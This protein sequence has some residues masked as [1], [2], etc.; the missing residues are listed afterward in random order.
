[1][2]NSYL[3]CLILLLLTSYRQLGDPPRQEAEYLRLYHY[4]EGLYNNPNDSKLNDSLA[5][6]SYLKVI[7]L[8][9]N[10]HQNDSVLWDCYFKAGIYEQTLGRYDKAIPYFLACSRLYPAL[11]Y[12]PSS[13]LYLPSLYTGNS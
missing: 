12:L 4:A 2:R 5:L 10:E 13:A 1:M 9:Q 3:L 8:L 6:S 11:T 7:S